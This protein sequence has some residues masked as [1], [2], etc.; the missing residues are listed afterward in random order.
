M[1]WQDSYYLN[2]YNKIYG[3]TIDNATNVPII[4]HVSMG[5]IVISK[6]IPQKN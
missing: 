1:T 5:G 3:T 4:K 6:A 2:N